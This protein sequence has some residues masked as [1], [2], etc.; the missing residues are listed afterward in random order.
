MKPK[1]ALLSILAW[2]FT[3]VFLLAVLV[4]W[5]KMPG[6]VQLGLSVGVMVFL[7][8]GALVAGIVAIF[9][10]KSKPT[11]LPTSVK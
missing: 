6:T 7:F 3:Y 9:T 4:F 10:R 2:F 11:K 5:N 8:S 1:K